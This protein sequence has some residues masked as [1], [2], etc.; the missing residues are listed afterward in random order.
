MKLVLFGGLIALCVG[1]P[2]LAD[3]PIGFRTGAA[4]A[5]KYKCDACHVAYDP[6]KGPSW[7]A[8]AKKYADDPQAQGE[9]EANVLNG[10][11]GVWGPIPMAPIEV[12]ERDLKPLIEWVLSLR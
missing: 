9:L 2:A 4:L 3:E 1:A 10:I 6:G 5:A 11:S 12:P 8:I 7:H